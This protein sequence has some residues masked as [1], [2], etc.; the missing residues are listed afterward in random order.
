[1]ESGVASLRELQGSFAAAMRDASAGCAVLPRD[2]LSIYR[3]NSS[4]AQAHALEITFPVLRRRVGDDYFRQLAAK[5][6]EA[7]PSRSGDLHWAGSDFDV[8]LASHLLGSDYAWLS[9]LARLEWSRHRASVAVAHAS[10]GPEVLGRY[11]PEQLEHLVFTLQPSLQL[12]ASDF[13]I[14]SV[15]ALNQV[16]NAPPVDQSLAGE[17]GMVRARADGVEVRRV[18]PALFSYLSALSAGAPLGEA[19]SS[20]GFDQEGLVNALGFVFSEN[21]V[22][23]VAI[24]DGRRLGTSS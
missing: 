16:D 21:L 14:F 18:E 11:A 19:V 13:P 10:M 5:F 2:N 8:F 3:N 6:R 1:L 7:F 9:D 22:C 23:A 20:A 12:H 17:C 24:K 15:W 4:Y